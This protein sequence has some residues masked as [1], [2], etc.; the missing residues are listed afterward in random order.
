[1]TRDLFP[2]GWYVDALAT[3]ERAVL[4]RDSH[5]ETHAGRLELDGGDNPLQLRVHVWNGRFYIA[6]Q[7]HQGRGAI[8]HDGERWRV[9]GIPA[10][11]V[12]SCLFNGP[13]LCVV[14]DGGH[15]VRLHLETGEVSEPI[16]MLLGVDGLAFV[17]MNG[18][19]VS[20][21]SVKA[22][23]TRRIWEYTETG[24]LTIGQGDRGC[25][26]IDEAGGRHLL[27]DGGTFFIHVHTAGDT[28][29]TSIVKQDEN[30][31]VVVT[32]TLA[33]ILSRPAPPGVVIPPV[34]IPPV[35]PPKPPI[36]PPQEPV[37]ENNPLPAFIA[38]LLPAW[39]AAYPV[40]QIQEG[41]GDDVFTER[42]R[43]WM[44]PLHE[45]IE[46]LAPGQGYGRKRGDPG[47]PWGKDTIPHVTKLGSDWDG[48]VIVEGEGWD[49]FTGTSAGHPSFNPNVRSVDLAR[50]YFET[51]AP[52]NHLGLDPGQPGGGG[53]HTP[54][55]T[56]TAPA[57]LP[58]SWDVIVAACVKANPGAAT[59]TDAQK[60]ELMRF[61]AKQLAFSEDSNVGTKRAAP[62]RDLS[63]NAIGYNAT[64]LV[65]Y[66]LFT[67]AGQ[68]IPGAKVQSMAGQVFE[69]VTPED[70]LHLGADKPPVDPP[71]DLAAALKRIDALEK[72]VTGVSTATGASI[73]GLKSRLARLEKK[74][75]KAATTA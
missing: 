44:L 24:A 50:Q 63:K 42:M 66:V 33:Q 75:R 52:V 55:T 7:S 57:A 19:P 22:D 3:G 31:A 9:L 23:V 26:A 39:I 32:A 6:G 34:V 11:G 72:R 41:E 27:E 69:A 51:V 13:Y 71:S 59:G 29:V 43:N 17:G 21:R 12:C 20:G 64:P 2:G 53:G 5:I 35:I 36:E 47:R 14:V 25:I 1:M 40:P 70:L 58:A 37:L 15:Y 67:D 16:A 73:A 68:V 28:V 61:I 46:F 8:L 4:F 38:N 45:Q 60:R 74:A 56:T 62:D 48:H 18:E 10:F 54:P 65:G 49:I 30:Q